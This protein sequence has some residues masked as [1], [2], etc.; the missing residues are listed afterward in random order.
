MIITGGGAQLNGL[1]ELAAE[2]MDMPI[3][4]GCPDKINGV[5]ET[6]RSSAYAAAAG[7]V[8]YGVKNLAYAQAAPTG[9]RFFGGIVSRVKQL[10]EDF[11]A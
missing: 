1:M 8:L 9:E 7:L 11:F 2:E 4:I 5:S 3:R 6:V 10:F